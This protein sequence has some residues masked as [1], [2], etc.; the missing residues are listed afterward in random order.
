[1]I[2]ILRFFISSVLLLSPLFVIAS[3][4]FT[5]RDVIEKRF[6]DQELQKLLEKISEYEPKV[7]QQLIGQDEAVELLFSK[8]NQYLSGFPTGHRG[9]PTALH[10]IGVPGVGKSALFQAIEEFIP[11][12]RLDAQAFSDPKEWDRIYYLLANN[13]KISSKR[14]VILLFEEIDKVRELDFAKEETTKGFIGFLNEVLSSG[15]SELY[16]ALDLSHVMLV[17]TMN[18]PTEVLEKFAQEVLREKKVYYDFS[19]KDLERF[20]SWIR[21]DKKNKY[22]I[23]AEMFRTNTVNRLAPNL[24]AMPSYSEETYL[25]IIDEKL[26]QRI[27][28]V[29]SNSSNYLKITYSKKLN[30]FLFQQYFIPAA[31]PRGLIMGITDFIDQVQSIASRL[32]FQNRKELVRPRNVEIKL[33]KKGRLKLKIE[34]LKLINGKR[35][36]ADT[37]S[38]AL[39]FNEV[40][41]VIKKPKQLTELSQDEAKRWTSKELSAT[42]I[43]NNRFPN[44]KID[45]KFLENEI[46]K[47][48]RGQEQFAKHI[49]GEMASYMS[50]SINSLREPKASIYSGFPGIGKTSGVEIVAKTLGI[51]IARVNLRAFSSSSEEASVLFLD[52]LVEAVEQAKAEAGPSGKY[53]LLLEE[54]DKLFEIDFHGNPID[55]PVLT[56]FNDLLDTGRSEITKKAQWSTEKRGVDV[57]GAYL[58]GTMNFNSN[59]FDFQADPRLTSVQEMINSWREI[60]SSKATLRE[61]LSKIFRAE[62]ISRILSKIIVVKPP[63]EKDYYQIIRDQVEIYTQERFKGV[64]GEEI[65]KVKLILTESYV[66]FLYRE[67]VIPSEG[68]R[69]TVD[70]VKKTLGLDVEYALRELKGSLRSEPIGLTLEYSLEDSIVVSKIESLGDRQGLKQVEY[71]RQ[72]E[73]SFPPVKAYGNISRE[74]FETTVHEFGHAYAAT[75][76]GLRIERVVVVSP[77]SGVGGF[78]SLKDFEKSTNVNEVIAKIYFGLGSRAM[79]RVIFG[80]NAQSPT[81]LFGIGLGSG[82]DL[83]SATEEIVGLFHSLGLNPYGP[84]ISRQGG[85]VNRSDKKVDFEEISEKETERLGRVLQEVEDFMVRDLLTS[86]SKEWYLEKIEILA[87]QGEMEEREFYELLDLK[88]PLH[89]FKLVDP[90]PRL[91]KA[92]ADRLPLYELSAFSEAEE[93]KFGKDRLSAKEKREL[94]VEQF[95]QATEKVYSGKKMCSK[96]ASPKK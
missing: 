96:S 66:D 62:T 3:E 38:I 74:R 64:D 24:Y 83:L 87:E 85:A 21:K 29:T 60:S 25:N 37:H 73:L 28:E 15:K 57:R 10:Y 75:F 91:S 44:T 76:L 1:M 19:L 14:P 65:G 27:I 93:N 40:S 86:H 12:V 68:P 6:G 92:L 30:E 94:Y 43:R 32:V 59:L 89:D 84:A 54:V 20:S 18:Y 46:L 50:A 16:R 26:K 55:R 13:P 51:P 69:Y 82:Q 67:N 4:K 33:D 56:I 70:S 5:Y 77:M 7:K 71:K 81:S 31:G 61:I 80:V 35:I 49:S 90:T 63:E 45:P 88:A 58:I 23:L 8:T 72:A 95:R 53:I 78:V 34:N 79:E 41:G 11:V 9:A 52:S 22:R 2:Q 48:N 42:E 47:V 17:S 39:D 36:V